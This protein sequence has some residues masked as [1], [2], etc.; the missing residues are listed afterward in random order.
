M[1]WAYVGLGANLGNP[2]L[3]VRLAMQKMASFPIKEMACSSMWETT[4]VACPPGSP[5]FVNAVAGL[6]IE[7]AETP[8]SL[9]DRLQEIEREFGRRRGT[10]VNEPRS[11]DLDL[12]AYGQE[13]RRTASLVLPHPRAH[14][15]RFV[16][17][18]WDEIAPDLILPG[19]SLPIRALLARLGSDEVVRRLTDE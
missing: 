15:R 9:L 18:P 12:L 19:Q 7:P 3:A 17:A 8:E 14:R 16:L 1:T 5:M 11:L 13:T 6:R 2:A 4:P 10:G